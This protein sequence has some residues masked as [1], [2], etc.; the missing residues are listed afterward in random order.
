MLSGQFA[1]IFFFSC[2]VRLYA[3]LT[4]RIRRFAAALPFC[5][6]RSARHTAAHDKFARKKKIRAG[7]ASQLRDE[8]VRRREWLTN[9]YLDAAGQLRE[10]WP[11]RGRVT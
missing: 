5:F 4:A 7:S 6:E 1:R 10:F 11:I 9:V 2:A 8:L 3:L